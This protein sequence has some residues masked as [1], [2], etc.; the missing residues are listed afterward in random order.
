MRIGAASA[1]LAL[2][3]GGCAAAPATLPDGVSV[4]V[5]QP[6][7][8]IASGR[9]AIQ[10]RNDGDRPI[11]VT[12]A[13]FE[14]AAFRDAVVWE[15]GRTV[16]IAPG[17]AVD[18]RIPGGE[19]D[20]GSAD[21]RGE[22]ELR[23]T[24]DGRS[25]SA[26]LAPQDEFGIIRQLHDAGCLVERVTGVA[27]LRTTGIDGGGPGVPGDLVIEI[28]PSGVGELELVTV[29]STTLLA[30][31][32]GGTGQP[33][34]VISATIGA[35]GPRQLRIPIVPNR[36]DPHALAEDKVG[37]R[38]PVEIRGDGFEGRIV[39]DATDEARGTM[40]AFF[41]AYCGF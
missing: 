25:G 21:V 1:A 3:L 38:I 32:V 23:F 12:G 6:R 26:T 15:G 30:P 41:A 18:L 8:E 16:R 14:T 40:R 11:E 35:D 39:L 13:A 9:L 36:C 5:Y 10:V 7:T 24:A 20:C 31:A 29:R 22:V 4:A 27:A 28:E 19:A 2:L 34:V 17:T 37:T 33:S